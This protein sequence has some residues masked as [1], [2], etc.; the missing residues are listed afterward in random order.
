LWPEFF[1]AFGRKIFVLLK[2]VYFV[3]IYKIG[4]KKFF[5]QNGEKTLENIK[6]F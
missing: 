2:N 4:L 5:W 3:K 6:Y 1:T